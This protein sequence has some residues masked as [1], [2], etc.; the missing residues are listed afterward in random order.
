M[1]SKDFQNVSGGV[2]LPQ[3]QTQHHH[4]N[5][6]F[7]ESFSNHRPSQHSHKITS[8]STGVQN[9]LNPTHSSQT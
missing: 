1:N 8:S 3:T 4:P 2:Q 9:N 7:F 6:V 5:E